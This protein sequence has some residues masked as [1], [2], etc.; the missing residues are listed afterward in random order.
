MYPKVITHNAI[1]LD[2]S[3]SGFA[4]DLE[5]YYAVAG[6]LNPD[7]MLVGSSTAKS[8][9]EMYSDGIPDESPS[10]FVKPK[11]ASEDKRPFWVIPDSHGLLQGRLHVFRRFEYC[12]DVII[13]LSEKS[14]ESYVKYLMERNYDVIISGHEEIDLKKSLEILADKYDCK[15]VMTD[16]GGNLNNVLLEAGLVDEISLIIHPALVDQRH[17]KLFRNLA[18]TSHPID[19]E[20]IRSDF[21]EK[22]IWLHF[23]VNKQIPKP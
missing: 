3:I 11:V 22:N 18:V 12:K 5:K 9:I 20:L 21:F 1:S 17:P 4:I 13:L 10:D 8:G 7:A 16:S 6:N 19:L 23:K 14:P 2:G 15:V